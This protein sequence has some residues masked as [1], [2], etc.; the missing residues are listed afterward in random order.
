[1][2]TVTQLY[3]A[4]AYAI[5]GNE[6]AATLKVR[7]TVSFTAQTLTVAV[8]DAFGHNLDFIGVH[9]VTIT[10]AGYTLTTPSK[11]FYPGEYTIFGAYQ[12]G[13]V[14]YSLPSVL[15]I[16]G[17]AHGG[18]SGPTEG[19]SVVWA[20][21]FEHP[22]SRDRWNSA[23]TSAYQYYTHNPND[24]KLDWIHADK[25]TVANNIVTF[26]AVPGNE[27]LE[28]GKKAWNTGLITTE[29][30]LE[31]FEVRANDYVETLV[32]MPAELGAW[33]ALWTWRD[34]DNE[35]DNFEYHPDN[36]NL[37]EFTNHVRFGQDYYTNA[38]AVA[39][40][41]W[42]T[43]GTLYGAT[44]VDWY[45]NGTRVFSDGTGV[46]ASWTAFLILNLSVCAGAFHPTPIPP[47]PLVFRADY[48]QVWR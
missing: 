48:I 25:V 42:V 45:I 23:G 13:G 40:L 4:P 21:H 8:R 28:N 41:V 37:L 46:P 26:T 38:Q 14:W 18:G 33:P 22:L 5:A 27:T 16:V 30:T 6:V 12:L 44:S 7:S 36:P 11:T 20:E 19:K 1:M 47:G 2:P 3:L 9:N 29:G 43:I 34:G 39:P 31:A 35:V 15:M 17:E 32:Q 24:D 10:P